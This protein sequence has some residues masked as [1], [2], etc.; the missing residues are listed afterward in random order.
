MSDILN[1]PETPKTPISSD[2]FDAVCDL[3]SQGMPILKAAKSIGVSHQSV[4][5][6]IDIIGEQA[7]RKW[8]R[9]RAIY[10]ESRMSERQDIIDKAKSE[11]LDCDPKQANA[12]AQIYKEEIRAIEW[13]IARVISRK[14]GDKLDIT[15]DH[16]ALPVVVNIVAGKSVDNDNKQNQ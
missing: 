4:Y 16:K 3:L 15:S 14:Y 13:E 2:Q 12:L 10:L 1:S 11:V 9:A 6:Y 8:M 5:N 7:E